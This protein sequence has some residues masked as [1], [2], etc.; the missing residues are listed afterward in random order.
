[1]ALASA[2]V[3][4]AVLVGCAPKVEESVRVDQVTPPRTLTECPAG[5]DAATVPPAPETLPPRAQLQ[6]RETALARR[7]RGWQ[8]REIDWQ[9]AHGR[10]VANAAALREMFGFDATKQGAPQ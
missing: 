6:A 8:R 4:G 5:P 9:R 7:E 3:L 2:V 1:M 10:C